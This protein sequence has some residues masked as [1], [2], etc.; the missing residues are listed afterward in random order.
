MLKKGTKK[1]NKQKHYVKFSEASHIENVQLE[2]IYLV[3]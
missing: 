3:N 2:H 1:K